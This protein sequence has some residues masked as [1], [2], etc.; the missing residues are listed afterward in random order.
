MPSVNALAA[1]R[2]DDDRGR[3]HPRSAG[4]TPT[5]S[6]GDGLLAG[7][8]TGGLA[9]RRDGLLAVLL[10]EDGRAVGARRA[11]GRPG[12]ARLLCWLRGL[13]RSRGV[14]G[15]GHASLPVR[16]LLDHQHL[17]LDVALDASGGPNLEA[18]AAVDVTLVVTVDDHVACL[19]RGADPGLGA[20]DQR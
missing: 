10:A 17:R 2:L 4:G 6:A 11:A 15:H 3:T 19:D 1:P 20:D 16:A 14:A 18:S 5:L 9:L 13:R 7:A 12:A 8:R